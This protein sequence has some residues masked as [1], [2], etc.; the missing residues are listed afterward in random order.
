MNE[1]FHT[2]FQWA[3]IY[4]SMLGLKLNHDSTVHSESYFAWFCFDLKQAGITHTDIYQ[5]YFTDTEVV[6]GLS[7]CQWSNPEEYG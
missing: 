5:G 2:T 4:L 3:Y 6:M 1:L 7:Q